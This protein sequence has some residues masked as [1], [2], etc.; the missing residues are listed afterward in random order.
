ML[1]D[2]TKRIKP[3]IIKKYQLINVWLSDGP[4]SL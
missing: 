1:S 4:K 2:S 3:G